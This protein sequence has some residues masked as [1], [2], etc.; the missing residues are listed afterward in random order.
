MPAANLDPFFLRPLALRAL[1]AKNMGQAS[2][3]IGLIEGNRGLFD[4]LDETGAASTAHLAR[5]LKAPV[6]LCIDCAKATRT[7]AALLNGLE[8]FEADL[9]FAGVVLNRIGSSRHESSLRRAIEANTNFKILGA[10]PRMAAN[11]LPERH[12]GLASSGGLE[13]APEAN[14]IFNKLAGFISANC[15]ILKIY[16]LAQAAPDLEAPPIKP[17]SKRTDSGPLIGVARDQAFWFYYPE[18]LEALEEAGC[19][20]AFLSFFDKSEAN[21]SAWRNVDGLY[22]GGG[23]PEDYATELSESP[24]L[25][26][27]RVCADA[28]MPIYAECGGLIALARGLEINGRLWPMAGVLPVTAVWS[29]KPQGLGY[30]EA[31]V[32]ADNPWRE[33]GQ[34]LVGHEFHYSICRPGREKMP[35]CLR[36]ERG[37]GLFGRG[38][39]TDGLYIKNVWASYLHIYAPADPDWAGRFAWLASAAKTATARDQNQYKR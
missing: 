20:L 30:V 12:M 14:A 29:D 36:L 1:F 28:G 15:D 34:K 23:F 9:D 10:L 32:E 18:N 6:L 5:V 24:Y 38:A 31:L 19:R 25:A 2:A 3:D 35:T 13:N 11:P 7:V 37:A 26:S 22:L 39:A 8:T 33:R 21:Q 27:L 4:G 17:A 16:G